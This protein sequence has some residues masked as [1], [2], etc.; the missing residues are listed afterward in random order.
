MTSL[1]TVFL[2]PLAVACVVV[3]VDVWVF[4]DARRLQRSGTPVV[5]RAGSFAIE[6]PEAWAIAC[7]LLFVFFV[8]LY[9]VARRA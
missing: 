8:P 7:L 4:A 6:T 9:A 1:F 5:A 3:T 2:A